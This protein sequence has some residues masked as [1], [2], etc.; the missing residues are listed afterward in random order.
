MSTNKTTISFRT[1]TLFAAKECVSKDATRYYLAGV[2]FRNDD[3]GEGVRIC[4]TNGHVL[5]TGNGGQRE[6]PPLPDEGVI[7]P[8][9]LLPKGPS[10]VVLDTFIEYDHE[11]RELKVTDPKG[12]TVL[13]T[14]I[15]GTYPDID[16]IVPKGDD[17][18]EA[19]SEI[20]MSAEVLEKINKA[21]RMF[22]AGS[23]VVSRM[24]FRGASNAVEFLA[25][26]DG[27]QVTG[28]ALPCRLD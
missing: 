6:G 4:A 27:Q 13:G 11:T 3:G 22:G 12:N 25:S 10:R 5:I 1:A 15:E 21:L 18:I 9:N 26:A 14:A 2:H 7:V 17:G 23:R 24:R 28:V 8:T 20:G 16:R 19:V